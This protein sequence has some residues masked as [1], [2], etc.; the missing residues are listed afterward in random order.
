[1]TGEND[2]R[3]REKR[4]SQRRGNMTG[5]NDDGGGEKR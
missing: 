2:E 3:G 5:E 4:R 1:M